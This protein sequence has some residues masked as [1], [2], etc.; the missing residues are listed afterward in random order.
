MEHTNKMPEGKTFKF[1]E[2]MDNAISTYDVEEFNKMTK[3]V[4]EQKELLNELINKRAKKLEETERLIQERYWSMLVGKD[5]KKI[6]CE[7]YSLQDVLMTVFVS[8]F[9][10]VVTTIM[11]LT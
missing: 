10:A 1:P 8:C 4:R 6:E 5:D 3:E 2:N 9:I 7:K 11:I